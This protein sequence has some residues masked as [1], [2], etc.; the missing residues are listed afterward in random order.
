MRRQHGLDLAE[1]DAH[2]AQLHAAVGAAEVLERAVVAAAGAVAGAVEP[3]AEP[4]T[5]RIGDE[6]LARALVVVAIAAR[7]P[8]AG[9][10]EVARDAGRHRGERV[11]E[12]VDAHSGERPSDRYRLLVARSSC[13]VVSHASV[14]P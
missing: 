3:I 2:A 6:A 4:G 10:V 8:V 13:A 7:E 12:Q 14:A 11:V 9:D 1:L 5:E